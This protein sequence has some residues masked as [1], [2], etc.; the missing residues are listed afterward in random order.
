MALEV[1]HM[2]NAAKRGVSSL[3]ALI[4]LLA[5]FALAGSGDFGQGRDRNV[6]PPITQAR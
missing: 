1:I 3:L 6:S 5:G 4:V 2:M